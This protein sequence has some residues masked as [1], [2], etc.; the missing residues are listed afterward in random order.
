MDSSGNINRSLGNIS[1]FES[2]ALKK[3]VDEPWLGEIPSCY[4]KPA[5]N[6]HI[7]TWN[8]GTPWRVEVM[9][10]MELA[11]VE[12]V[13]IEV[14]PAL[15]WLGGFQKA[16]KK[17]AKFA[18]CVLKRKIFFCNNQVPGWII[19]PT[20]FQVDFTFVRGK[21]NRLV[22][23]YPAKFCHREMWTLPKLQFKAWK[24][25]F[26][27]NP[28]FYAGRNGVVTYATGLAFNSAGGAPLILSTCHMAYH[29]L[30]L[31]VAFG[32]GH[33]PVLEAEVMASTRLELSTEVRRPW[34]VRLEI[35]RGWWGFTVK[36]RLVR[37]TLLSSTWRVHNQ[38]HLTDEDE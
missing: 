29:D 36:V 2:P 17:V 12:V 23:L 1:E 33:G 18:A 31:A 3:N 25:L 28:F 37:W 30:T 5:S 9:E 10:V 4:P 38:L 35:C 22:N 8:V 16:P 20:Y 26:K 7:F 6:W 14:K 34:W 24:K 15:G 21:K 13:A 32:A 19:F 11:T 27:L